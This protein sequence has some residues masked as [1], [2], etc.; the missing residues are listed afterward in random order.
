MTVR[1]VLMKACRV[2]VHKSPLA[3]CACTTTRRWG[4]PGRR[5]GGSCDKECVSDAR[6]A[7]K[8]GT[9]GTVGTPDSDARP[10]PWPAPVSPPSLFSFL[11]P[12]VAITVC[13]SSSSSSTPTSERRTKG[14]ESSRYLEKGSKEKAGTYGRRSR[15]ACFVMDFWNRRG[16][17]R[18]WWLTAKRKSVQVRST[19]WAASGGTGLSDLVL[20]EGRRQLFVE[21]GRLR[22]EV[23]WGQDWRQRKRIK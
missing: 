21:G 2:T 9:A 7:P 13:S 20:R 6:T 23:G 1:H 14:S 8:L 10:C 16:A 5:R 19:G 3:A 12:S 4:A 17:T 15:H 22:D 11:L 18:G